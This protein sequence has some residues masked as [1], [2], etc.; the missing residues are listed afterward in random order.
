MPWISSLCIYPLK[1]ARGVAVGVMELD[2]RGARDDRRWMAVGEDGR[3]LSQRTFPALALVQP[4]LTIDGLLLSAP[5]MLPLAVRRPEDGAGA[6]AI[7]GRLWDSAVRVLVAGDA[8]N[9]WLTRVLGVPTRLVYQPDEAGPL[10]DD[11][12]LLL[13]GQSSLDDLNRRLETPVS[14]SRFRPNIVVQGA[15]PYAE[16]AWRAIRIGDVEFEISGACSRCAATTIDQ[17]T[18]QRGVEPLRTLATY[19]KAGSGVNFGQNL[20]HRFPGT[21]RVGDTVSSISGSD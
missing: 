18:G 12:P 4:C 10:T 21:V 14:M 7:E 19:R 20:S 13:V 3:F 16:D 8:A 15:E 1:S 9:A 5:G 17:E 11:S 2:G 6:I